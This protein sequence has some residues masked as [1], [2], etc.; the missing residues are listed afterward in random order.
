[1]LTEVRYDSK[2]VVMISSAG[3]ASSQDGFHA[4]I[5]GVNVNHELLVVIQGSNWMINFAL[6]CFSSELGYIR[7]LVFCEILIFSKLFSSRWSK[8]LD[9]LGIAR[10]K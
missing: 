4:D 6:L 2:I 5:T 7:G 3:L 10:D 9:H 1:M 8:R